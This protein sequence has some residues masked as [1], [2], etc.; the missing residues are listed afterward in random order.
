MAAKIPFGEITCVDPAT[1]VQQTWLRSRLQGED[2]HNKR[3]CC[4]LGKVNVRTA[5]P[6]I[7]WV[8]WRD[9]AGCLPE[10]LNTAEDLPNPLD[11][12]SGVLKSSCQDL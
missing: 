8:K 2:F 5:E 7:A 11:T 6:Q 3:V 12:S 9:G 4:S 10:G 1:R